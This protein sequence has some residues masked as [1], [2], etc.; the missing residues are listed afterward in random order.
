MSF[1]CIA[2]GLFISLTA[3]KRRKENG[4]FSHQ[5]FHFILISLNLSFLE[6]MYGMVLSFW[7]DFTFYTH[8]NIIS[9]FQSKFL[10]HCCYWFAFNH[11]GCGIKADGPMGERNPR[12]GNV[13][14]CPNWLLR[15]CGLLLHHQKQAW[16][17]SS[18]CCYKSSFLGIRGSFYQC[19]C[20]PTIWNWHYLIKSLSYI[21]GKLLD[22]ET[23]CTI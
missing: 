22:A 21:L 5:R 13:S 23:E 18:S 15:C 19:I 1:A 20:A 3:M 16:I 6:M 9:K 14:A 11:E 10:K 17:M 2:A 8:V 4:I 7:S 12:D